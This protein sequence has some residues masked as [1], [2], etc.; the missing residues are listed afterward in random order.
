MHPYDVEDFSLSS[1]GVITE[2]ELL[3]RFNPVKS[4]QII[5]KLK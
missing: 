2:G 3:I 1:N 4:E 5:L